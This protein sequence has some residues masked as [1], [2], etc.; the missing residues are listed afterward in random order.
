MHLLQNHP[1]A[2]SLK[3]HLVWVGMMGGG[4][5][6]YGRQWELSD[7]SEVAGSHWVKGHEGRELGY[8][9]VE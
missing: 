6:M 3:A 9:W 5:H 4:L 1:T 8:M 2:H 7:Y